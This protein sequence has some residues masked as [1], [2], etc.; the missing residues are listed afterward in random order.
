MGTAWHVYLVECADGSLYCGI[1]TNLERRLAAHNGFRSGG[2]KYTRSRRPVRLV[3]SAPRPDK[4][5]A[6][7][8]ES[9]IRSVPRTQKIALLRALLTPPPGEPTIR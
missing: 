9:Q 3:A 1:T 4:A 8:L 6:A 2:A 7:R 5:S